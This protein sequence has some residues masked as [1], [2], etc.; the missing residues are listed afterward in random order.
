[1]PYNVEGKTYT[2]ARRE[3]G[4]AALG[5]T[6]NTMKFTVKD[7]DPDTGEPD[8][9]GYPD[10][11]TIEDIDISIGDYMQPAPI[12]NFKNAWDGLDGRREGLPAV[13][14]PESNA[15]RAS[16]SDG[17]GIPDTRGSLRNR[18]TRFQRHS[19]RA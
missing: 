14:Q 12:S 5:K 17:S 1:M 15:P 3:D 6:M 19:L 8:D 9:A 18:T 11:Y 10:E 4:I 7:C 16:D 2:C 13:R